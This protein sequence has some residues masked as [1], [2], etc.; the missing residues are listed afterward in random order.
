MLTTGVNCILYGTAYPMYLA[1]AISVL[2]HNGN[3]EE[4]FS[5][6]MSIISIRAVD[7]LRCEGEREII[8]FFLKRIFC[9]CLKATYAQ[10]KESHP[11]RIGQC[12]TCKQSQK[13]SSLMLCGRCKSTQY[14]C[15]ECQADD[16]P[17]HKVWCYEFAHQCISSI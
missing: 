13:L 14:C 11:I 10:I 8:Q 12:F 5:L 9:C 3:G 7:D 1:Q 6:G 17:E 2:E 15:R 16:W 4:G